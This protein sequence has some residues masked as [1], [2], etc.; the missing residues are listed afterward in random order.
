MMSQ[1]GPDWAEQVR[2]LVEST[3]AEQ[4]LPVLVAD[5]G[6]V[7]RVAVLLRAGR[8]GAE[9][10]SAEREHAAV[11]RLR[12]EA[13]DRADALDGHLAGSHDSGEDHHVVNDSPHDRSLS[14]EVETGPLAS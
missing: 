11:G 12:S 1:R 4:G 6:A 5:R 13:P 7:D 8:A 10:A 9:G 3:C 14:V 2:A